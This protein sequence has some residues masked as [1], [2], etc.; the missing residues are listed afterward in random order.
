MAMMDTLGLMDRTLYD[1]GGTND[2]LG[3]VW[4]DTDLSTVGYYAVYAEWKTN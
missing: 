1:I 2:I 3:D 4:G